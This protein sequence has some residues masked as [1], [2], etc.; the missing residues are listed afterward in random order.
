MQFA[1]DCGT[2]RTGITLLELSA[3]AEYTNAVP[4][5]PKFWGMGGHIVKN[6]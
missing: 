5:Q 1:Q 2:T 6:E 4:E 3:P